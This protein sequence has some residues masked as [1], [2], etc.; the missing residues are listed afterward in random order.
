[1]VPALRV[2]LHRRGALAW[3]HL[4]GTGRELVSSVGP[5]GWEG[6]GGAAAGGAGTTAE[7][8]PPSSGAG[9]VPAARPRRT[10]SGLGSRPDASALGSS[11]HSGSP[12][13]GQGHENSQAPAPPRPRPRRLAMAEQLARRSVG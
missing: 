9:A 2:V 10:Y 12:G 11:T 1:M 13:C 5:G 7:G 3:L 8:R 6:R 4:Q